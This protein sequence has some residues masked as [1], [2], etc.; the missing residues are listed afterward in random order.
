MVHMPTNNLPHSCLSTDRIVLVSKLL[1]I[2]MSTYPSVRTLWD[3]LPTD[4]EANVIGT[5]FVIISLDHNGD[6]FFLLRL[7]FDCLSGLSVDR[8]S[9][10]AGPARVISCLDTRSQCCV[11][12]HISKRCLTP[13]LFEYCSNHI[14]MQFFLQNVR[15]YPSTGTSWGFWP[16][17]CQANVLVS[18]DF[19]ILRLHHRLGRLDLFCRVVGRG[20]ATGP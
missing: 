5:Y 20:L 13:K 14:S 1:S 4:F 2:K 18:A 19:I 6:I 9:L 11:E 8:R 7:L 12:C 15:T 10:A 17:D 3:L 16:T